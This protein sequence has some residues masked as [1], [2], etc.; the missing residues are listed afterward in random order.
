MLYATSRQQLHTSLAEVHRSEEI[1]REDM[2]NLL[3][4]HFF[5]L[6]CHMVTLIVSYGTEE[7]PKFSSFTSYRLP[8]FLC[9][10]QTK[11]CHVP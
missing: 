7:K 8:V 4:F 1:Q 10:P 11:G 3:L 9:H 5:H 2:V 6:S